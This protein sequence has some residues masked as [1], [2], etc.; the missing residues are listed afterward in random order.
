MR[1][2]DTEGKVTSVLDA[3]ILNL[4]SNLR[5]CS[6]CRDFTC[7]TKVRAASSQPARAACCV[8]PASLAELPLRDSQTGS[9]DAHAPPVV[10]ICLFGDS[11]TFQAS[12]RRSY[13]RF[14]RL[15][16]TNQYSSKRDV[17]EGEIASRTRLRWA[18]SSCVVVALVTH[19]TRKSRSA[20]VTY[21]LRGFESAQQYASLP[22]ASSSLLSQLPS[23]PLPFSV[24]RARPACRRASRWPP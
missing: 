18:G 9:Q 19:S 1:A 13:L 3:S 7:H 10:S 24:S 16:A 14:L 17:G 15:Q 11:T 4:T 6:G 20:R 5:M 2:G 22:A 8:I 21:Q 23:W 12:R